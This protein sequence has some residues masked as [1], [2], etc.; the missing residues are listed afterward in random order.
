MNPGLPLPKQ[1]TT[2]IAA[3]MAAMVIIDFRDLQH[4]NYPRIENSEKRPNTNDEIR[5]FLA[6]KAQDR[7]KADTTHPNRQFAISHPIRWI[8]KIARMAVDIANNHILRGD[9]G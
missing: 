8:L 4:Q 5:H 9:F 2:T 7:A 6:K 1:L 3:P